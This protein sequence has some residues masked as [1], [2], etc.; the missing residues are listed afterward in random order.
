MGEVWWEKR[1]RNVML[2]AGQTGS[3]SDCDLLLVCVCV[4]ACV[5]LCVYWLNVYIAN[6]NQC[7]HGNQTASDVLPLALAFSAI[8]NATT[9]LTEMLQIAR[10]SKRGA[11]LRNRKTSGEEV[12][13]RGRGR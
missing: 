4:L 13:G 9:T 12:V 8:T 1:K 3:G 7:F 2:M 10:M 11:H 5:C 6:A